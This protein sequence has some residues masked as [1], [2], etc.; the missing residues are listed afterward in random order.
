M[1]LIDPEPQILTKITK[2][3]FFFELSQDHGKFLFKIKRRNN[4]NHMD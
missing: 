4:L 1:N 2:S 3:C